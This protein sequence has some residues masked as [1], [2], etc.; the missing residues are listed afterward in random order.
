MASLI[1]VGVFIVDS[2]NYLYSA[3]L[4]YIKYDWSWLDWLCHISYLEYLVFLKWRFISLI[5][6]SSINYV[7]YERINYVA[8]QFSKLI[9]VSFSY[10]SLNYVLVILYH[11]WH[12][13]EAWDIQSTFIFFG[14]RK[15]CNEVVTEFVV[16]VQI[17]K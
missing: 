8:S 17:N 15:N 6:M 10:V 1:L 14:A 16:K 7:N 4:I 13:P 11:R 3:C 2:W 12:N 9:R 5:T